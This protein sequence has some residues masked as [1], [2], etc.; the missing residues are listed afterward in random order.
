MA[1]DLNIPLVKPGSHVKQVKWNDGVFVLIDKPAG[2]TSFDVVNKMR[3]AL[4]RL[5]GEKKIKVG[6]AGT[7]DPMATGLLLI[8][9][10]K[11][12]KQIQYI[13]GLDKRYT[14][15][16]LMGASTPSYDKETP[17]DAEFPTDDIDMEDFHRVVKSQTGA[18]QQLPPAYSA[19]KKDGRPLYLAARKGEVV[20][21]HPRP[22]HVYLF[23][24]NVTDWPEVS[25]E[26]H[27]SKGTYIRSLAHD[28]GRLLNNGAHLTAL[29]RT[30]IGS[31]NLADAWNLEDWL[32][33]VRNPD[34]NRL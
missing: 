24:T 20:Q 32:R 17:V 7:L 26:V 19:I 31:H 12:T 16:F 2:W 25:F 11:A 5:T 23:E 9:I 34:E 15:K 27:C 29:C 3:F 30:A 28:V 22:V 4:R 10:G 13:M 6:H 8:A 33:A 18:L 21:L 1:Q 14:G